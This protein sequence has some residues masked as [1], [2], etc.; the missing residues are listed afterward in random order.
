MIMKENTAGLF[1]TIEGNDGAG[2]TTAAKGLEQSLQA[3][4]IPVILT[5]EPGGSS[6]AEQI[7]EVLLDPQN[8]DMDPMT[9]AILYA[10]ARRQHLSDIVLPALK[11]GKVVLCDRYID[12]S[13]A[14]QGEGR[15]LGMDQVAALNEIA[16]EGLWPDV[17]LFLEV[18]PETA[19]ERILAR[20]DLN[21]LDAESEEFHARV[22]RGFEKAIARDPDRFVRVDASGTPEQVAEACLQALSPYLEGRDHAE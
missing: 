2:K 7:R 20:G 4:G 19:R 21:R 18:S 6:I 14:Y 17:T 1:V 12:S 8:T 5:R 13:L 16:T 22:R 11:A 3:A 10:A 9:E 15:N